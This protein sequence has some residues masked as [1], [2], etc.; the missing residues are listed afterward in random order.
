MNPDLNAVLQACEQLYAPSSVEE[1]SGKMLAALKPVLPSKCY[2]WE[3]LTMAEVKLIDARFEHDTG[4]V[5]WS[6]QVEPYREFV[7]QHPF[8]AVPARG[9]GAASPIVGASSVRSDVRA[10]M[11]PRSSPGN[12]AARS[13]HAEGANRQ[14]TE[15]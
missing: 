1:F 2:S 9:P 14:A 7:W 5:N 15:S 13:R 10:S 12:N 4:A 8:A 3:L 6:K 11:F